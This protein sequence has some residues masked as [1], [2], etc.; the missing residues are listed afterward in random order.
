MVV[1]FTLVSMGLT[2]NADSLSSS[3]EDAAI[4]IMAVLS[5]V[6][7]ILATIIAFIYGIVMLVFLC[8]DSKPETNKYGPSPKYTNPDD[9]G[10]K[11]DGE[12]A[13]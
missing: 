7:I 1:I 2:A 8:Q 13:L 5:S 6:Q 12:A 4:M 3:P 9:T 10:I 11:A